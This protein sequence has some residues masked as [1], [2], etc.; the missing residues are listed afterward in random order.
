MDALKPYLASTL[1]LPTALNS[2]RM[3]ACV[4]D[5]PEMRETLAR[6]KGSVKRRQPAWLNEKRS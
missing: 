1:A 4:Y 5:T 3:E 2:K 6:I